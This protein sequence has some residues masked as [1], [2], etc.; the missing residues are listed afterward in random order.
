MQLFIK[1]TEVTPFYTFLLDD[2][3]LQMTVQGLKLKINEITAVPTDK[4]VLICSARVLAEDNKPLSYYGVTEHS[5]IHLSCR[6]IPR[7]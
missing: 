7:L 6:F 2:I 3:Y 4:I 5:T 1:N